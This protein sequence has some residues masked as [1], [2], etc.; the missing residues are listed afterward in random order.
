MEFEAITLRNSGNDWEYTMLRD[1]LMTGLVEEE[2][3]EIQAFRPSIVYLNGI[4]WGIHN[5]REK[6]NEHFIEANTGV[7]SDNIDLLEWFG[8]V[9]HGD[10]HH[11]F[12]MI[13]FM[14]THAMSMDASYEYI[15]TQIDIENFITYQATQIFIDNRDWPG[16]NIKYWRPRTETGK[17]R[18]ILYDTDFG[19]GIFESDAASFNTLE[20]ATEANGPDW[21]NPPW[22]TFMLRRLLE[23]DQ[24]KHDF[25]NRF[26]DML[27]TVFQPTVIQDQLAEKVELINDEIVEHYQRWNNYSNWYSLIQI[28]ENFA[29][30]RQS[31]MRSH[32]QSYFQLT[33]MNTISLNVIPV[34]SGKI[35]INATVLDEFPWQGDY[36][37]D[38]PLQLTAVPEPGYQFVG[39]E[40]LVSSIETITISLTQAQLINAIFEPINEES[41]PV[42]INEINYNSSQYFDVEDW[43]EILNRTDATIDISGWLIK[44]EDDTHMYEIP[45]N[46]A[47]ESGCF[48]VICK[49]MESFQELFPD[50][51]NCIGNMDFGFSSNGETIRLFDENENLIDFVPYNSEGDWPDEPDGNGA[52]L[53]LINPDYDNA[54]P[55]NWT[56][57]DGNGTPGSTNSVLE[58]E[59]VTEILPEKITLYGN[60]PNPFN[61]TTSVVF[62]LQKASNIALG[63]YNIKGQVVKT[64]LESKMSAGKHTIIWNG[65]NNEGDSVGSGIYFY[66]ITTNES[67]SKTRRMILIK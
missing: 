3:I 22:S 56:A 4:Y 2:D 50:I 39:W 53:E 14:E 60:Y 17:W 63:I 19:F 12:E 64:F 36:F 15:K 54:I 47:L 21:P 6:S 26:C 43:V 38:I 7:D 34:N 52:T 29:I 8:G 18:W 37:S 42:V 23:N 49:N 41:S 1:G 32:L 65:K 58:N 20:Y 25:I 61:P 11:F 30:Q 57:S 24:F 44:D 28:M 59:I 31:Y 10:Q 40:G 62:A 66:R 33:G 5:I 55:Q 35:R 27:N 45:E 16:N 67:N 9:V 13:E 48:L 46:T 51:D